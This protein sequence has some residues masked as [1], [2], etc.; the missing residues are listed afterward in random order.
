MGFHIYIFSQQCF[1][2]ENTV[3][4]VKS[5]YKSIFKNKDQ[6]K[7]TITYLITIQNKEWKN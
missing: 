6:Y 1:E 3:S 5:S 4:K 7:G 2:W